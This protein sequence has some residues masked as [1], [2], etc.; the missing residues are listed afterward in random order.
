[1][2]DAADRLLPIVSGAWVVEWR[3]SGC[4]RLVYRGEKQ[5][6][7]ESLHRRY[8]VVNTTRMMSIKNG[9][10]AAMLTACFVGPTALA[11]P[12]TAELF[13]SID[14]GD[15]KFDFVEG[16]PAQNGNQV[17]ISTY[18]AQNGTWQITYSLSIDYTAD[19]M[20][21]ANGTVTVEN[22][23]EID[24]I[25]FEVGAL[26]PICPAIKD[27]SLVGGSALLTL[28]TVGPGTLACDIDGEPILDSIA[29]GHIV[30][31]I[32]YCPTTLTSTGSSII[33]YSGKFGLP[34]P[35]GKGPESIESIGMREHFT[36]TPKDKLAMQF[37]FFFKDVDGVSRP[38]S[39]P[40]D[41]D[42]DGIVG[43]E[44]LSFVFA[45][46]GMT[47]SCPG[48]LPSDADGSGIVGSGDLLLVLT[49]WGACE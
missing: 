34:G 6:T 9:C 2:P 12:P 24:V 31:S 3:S 38:P 32:F 13:F 27:G 41:I 30:D 11:G 33:S 36:L 43:P 18:A 7:K 47:A 22:K 49:E 40:A 23:S 8:G 17:Y 35:S 19:P 5:M 21:V 46:W 48:T 10:W 4:Q 20:A 45:D 26:V 29:D 37:T 28:T 44:D 39:C 15:V 1:M 16:S 42:G 14:H 25:A